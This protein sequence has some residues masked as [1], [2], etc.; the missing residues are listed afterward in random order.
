MPESDTASARPP[1]TPEVE[2]LKPQHPLYARFVKT[3]VPQIT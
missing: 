1:W 3:A 2:Q